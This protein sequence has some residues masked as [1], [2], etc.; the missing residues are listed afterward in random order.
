MAVELDDGR[1]RSPRAVFAERF[2]KLHAAAG[3]PTLRRVA[4]AA[5]D[6]M[7]AARGNRPGGASAQRIS[8]WKAGRNVPARF[9]SLL[10]V[11]LTLIEL[12]SKAGNPLPPTLA[13]PAEWQRLWREATSWN[14]G[15]DAEAACPY[16]GL[17]AYGAEQRN[18]F[19]GRSRAVTELTDAVRT[20]TG[21]TA[22]IGA[23]G[24]GKSSLLAAGLAP[25]LNDWE[26]TTLTPGSHPYTA[27][28][29]ALGRPG[30]TPPTE[31]EGQPAERD[32]PSAR[33][34][35]GGVALA[36][37]AARIGGPRRLVVVD[38]LEE[39]F[40][41]CVDERERELF[42][43]VLD[44]VASRAD[45]P[46]AV[47]VALRADFYAHCLNHLILQDALEH[48]G[49]LLGPL[50]MDELSQAV[51]G[52]A[53]AVGLELEPGLEELI[54]TELCGAGD[55]H[56]RR[57]YDPGALPM[58]S[59]VMAATWQHREGRRLTIA[60]YR[61]AGGVVGSVAETAE[62]AWN[63]L[64]SDQQRAARELLLGLVTV[65]QDSRDTRRTVAR[66]DLLRRTDAHEDAT[67]AL[68]LLARTR[69]I[70]LDADAVTLTHEIVLTAWPRLRGWIDEDRV[71]YLIRQR[72]ES[73]A[74]EWAAQER[75]PSLLYRGSRLQSAR[76]H[77]DPPPIGP[78]AQEFLTRSATA[79][80][81]TRRRSR[82][83]RAVLAL[84]GVGL[85][86]VGFG[87]YSQI[88]LA[89]QRDADSRFAAVLAAADRVQHTDPSLAAQLDLVAWRLR[90]GDSTVRSRLLQ[91]QATP[92]VTVTPG[93]TDV[94]KQIAF[95]PSARTLASVD[96]S[97]NLQLWD[98]TD[99][100]HP[101]VRGQ[102]LTGIAAVALDT[103]ARLMATS[104]RPGADSNSIPNAN[105]IV[106]LW[107]IS[108]PATPRQLVQLPM[109]SLETQLAIS[110]DGRTLVTMGWR[111]FTLWDIGNPAAPIQR[112]SREL[113]T[114]DA[115]G[116]TGKVRFSPDGRLLARA[117]REGSPN[118]NSVQL[119]DVS[120]PN[121]PTLVAPA[122]A[123]SPESVRQTGVVDLDFRPDS[124]VLAVGITPES[125]SH[126]IVQLWDLADPAHPRMASS[127]EI[128]RG[129]MSALAFAPDGHALAVAV[130]ETVTV[131]NVTDPAD[132]A[133]L[134][135]DLAVTAGICHS[136]VDDHQ[137]ECVPEPRTLAFT[138][139]GRSVLTGTST[140]DVHTW[141][142]PTALTPTAPGSNEISDFAANGTEL[143]VGLSSRDTA[144]LWDIRNLQAPR[145]ITQ[146]RFAHS[147]G[148]SRLSSDGTLLLAMDMSLGTVTLIDVTDPAAIHPR[149]TWTFPDPSAYRYWQISPDLRTAVTIDDQKVMQLWDL[150]NPSR[151]T[152]LGAAV[153]LTENGTFSF[154]VD[155]KTMIETSAAGTAEEITT[156]WSLAN[157]SHPSRV[158][159]L[160][161]LP[162]GDAASVVIAPDLRTM[163]VSE[164]GT[165]QAWDISDP[166]RIRKL[167]GALA[168]KLPAAEAV[169]FTPDSQRLLARGSDG[170]VQLWDFTDRAHPTQTAA[171]TSTAGYGDT[172]AAMSLGNNYLAAITTEGTLALWDFD[173]QHAIDRI[174]SITGT[175]WT[176]SLWHRYLPQQPY[177][178]PCRAT[179]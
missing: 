78:L 164:K 122:F 21:L 10:P 147:L 20:A 83:L 53:R 166:H 177:Q 60:G 45:D 13:D 158:A 142:L 134:V 62:Y 148:S 128:D 69:L 54:T 86:V 68:E 7:R 43:G 16:P 130:G 118:L 154:G 58:L 155:G 76:E 99:P 34:S 98:T 159:E 64:S 175:F 146:Y 3:N 50:R 104:T 25:A 73:D 156:L 113:P 163:V 36:L 12:A 35:D 140:G 39:L 131:W 59:H 160:I 75:D 138:A 51:S 6:R 5:E 47:V 82:G 129:S 178:A 110:P 120:Q 173:T 24:A 18:L 109:L 33:H 29:E 161:R 27:L 90:P 56:G 72:L 55:R 48:R 63:E 115:Y 126:G 66:D 108:D 1:T 119:W 141:S 107:D 40:T 100:K 44:S 11:V 14:P 165:V 172:G 80:S 91:S 171:L 105:S 162:E 121:N 19:F 97:G 70:T 145:T 74:A 137:Y 95:Q 139:D 67:A 85:L 77:A 151:T 127:R 41:A 88:R 144:T 170:A 81:T 71:G 61:R 17:R 9:E 79:V 65:S 153:P 102:Q 37:S 174:C 96:E 42:L 114:S 143:A 117:N 30:A 57:T 23:S 167:G 52:P 150:S 124:A 38:Q 26:I 125:D 133:L 22:V 152:P 176:E 94:I 135:D 116:S 31:S 149:G 157:R 15:Q 106:T 111:A 8:D 132:P 136:P 123:I 2:D 4:S 103:T 28:L 49:Y 169:S 46:V 112:A 101:R 89:D 168:G 179:S 87:L 92:L 32:E 84:F 93:H